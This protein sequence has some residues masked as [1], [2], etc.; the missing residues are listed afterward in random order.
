MQRALQKVGIEY[1]IISLTDARFSKSSLLN[2]L[3]DRKREVLTKA[4]K[5]DIMIFQGRRDLM[6]WL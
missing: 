1:K 5:G 4:S 2:V 6:N 3:T